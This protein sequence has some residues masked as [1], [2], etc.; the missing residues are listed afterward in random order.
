MN[1]ETFPV[2][3]LLA[4]PPGLPIANNAIV[5]EFSLPWFKTS[6]TMIPTAKAAPPPSSSF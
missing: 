1:I 2:V 4:E 6:E 5:F 3:M